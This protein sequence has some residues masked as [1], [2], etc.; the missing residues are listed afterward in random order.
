MRIFLVLI[1]FLF[2]SCIPPMGS[3]IKPEVINDVIETDNTSDCQCGKTDPPS[4]GG[5]I[6]GVSWE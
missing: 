4:G 6:I 2:I 5:L 3:P 1:G